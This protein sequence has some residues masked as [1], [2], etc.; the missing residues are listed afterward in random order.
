MKREEFE[1][2]IAPVLAKVEENC[3]QLFSEIM[4]KQISIHSI[5]VIGGCSRI[6]AI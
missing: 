2:L 4:S 5:E 6:P 3:N 1:A